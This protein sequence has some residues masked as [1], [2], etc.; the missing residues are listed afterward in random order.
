M[1]GKS[2]RIEDVRKNIWSSQV[3]FICT[4]LQCLCVAG[5]RTCACLVR[6]LASVHRVTWHGSV[7]CGFSR[8]RGKHMFYFISCLCPQS[9]IWADSQG[10]INYIQ[11]HKQTMIKEACKFHKERE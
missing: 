10:A 9:D 11:D 4:H 8:R 5:I 2:L 3:F 6:S 1:A 7:W